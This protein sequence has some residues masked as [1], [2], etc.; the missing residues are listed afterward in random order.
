MPGGTEH[1]Q[2]IN[3]IDCGIEYMSFNIEIE[4]L[5]KMAVLGS[6]IF[7]AIELI[8]LPIP[9]EASTFSLIFKNKSIF[10]KTDSKKKHGRRLIKKTFILLQ[11]ILNIGFFL[12]PLM[13][14]F[15][16]GIYKYLLPFYKNVPQLLH[17]ISTCF[18][19]WGTI[20][21]LVGTLEL[22]Y[23]LHKN[24][25]KPRLKTNGVFSISRNPIV[26]GMIL[27]YLG[28]ILVVPSWVMILGFIV[29]IIYMHFRIQ[30]EEAYLELTF[31]DEYRGYKRKVGRYFLWI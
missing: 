26:F 9:S 31:G 19:I 17:Y 29:Y 25:K 28:F 13:W 20:F 4:N 22:R 7:V 5:L 23:T 21:T 11:S 3:K 6:Y 27:L 30:I 12:I 18:M 8:F 24:Q 1:Q 15:Y 16:S 2:E 10:N 14:I